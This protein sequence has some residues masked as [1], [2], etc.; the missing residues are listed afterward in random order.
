MSIAG[1][2]RCQVTVS[3]S[4]A[5]GDGDV[6]QAGDVCAE[7]LPDPALDLFAGFVVAAAQSVAESLEGV[8]GLGQRPFAGLGDLRGLLGGV[9]VRHPKRQRRLGVSPRYLPVAQRAP[10]PGA[11]LGRKFGLSFGQVADRTQPG[12]ADVGQKPFAEPRAGAQRHNERDAR[13]VDLAHRLG[14]PHRGVAHDQKSRPGNL[15]QPLQRRADQRQLRR[16]AWIR[17]AVEHRAVR[18]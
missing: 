6:D 4:L 16:V 8:L 15:K 3:L 9:D 18:G 12:V 11:Q 17:T 13:V 2:L 1:W 14:L 7:D 5:A 10:K